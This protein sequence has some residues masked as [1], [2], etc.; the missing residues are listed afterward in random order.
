[1]VRTTGATQN[2]VAKEGMV[3]Y[4]T[5]GEKLSKWGQRASGSV[6]DTEI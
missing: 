5:S 6:N 3:I 4:E 1:M 2:G